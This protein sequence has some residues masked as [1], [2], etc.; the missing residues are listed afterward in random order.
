MTVPELYSLYLQSSGITTD[1]RKINKNQLFFALKGDNFNGNLY[2]S[3]AMEQGA[4]AC[5]VDEQKYADPQKGIFYFENSLFALQNLARHHRKQLNIPVI[6]ITG[7][8]GKTTSKELIASVLKEKY[9]VLFTQGNLNNHIG[10]PL[11]VLSIQPKHEI[12]IIEMGA[13][14][15]KEIELLAGISMPDI[16]YITNF[17]KAHLEGFGGFEG[18]IKGKSELYAFLKESNGTALVNTDDPKQVELT[19]DIKQITFGSEGVYRF[20]LKESDHFVSV[21]YK[22]NKFNS[23]LTGIYNFSNICAAASLGFYLG[24]TAFQVKNGIENYQPRNQRSQIV[25]KNGVRLLLDTYNAN[26]SSME[27]SLKNFSSFEGSKAIIIGDMFELG[28]SSADE[29]QKIAELAQNLNFEYI[30]LVGS[31]FSTTTTTASQIKK[32]K[33]TED[34]SNYLKNNSLTSENILLKGSRG[35]ALEKLIDFI[36]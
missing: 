30:F 12:A 6:G 16:G 1:S 19:Q 25:K 8:N 28:D 22:D 13:N 10:V 29:H 4:L 31:N 34:M 11:T 14:H 24:L 15:Q 20:G 27:A 9:N 35:M 21:S 33:S 36:Y 3:Q 7:S 32:F 23:Q 17:G 18:V 26:P 5:V 2:A